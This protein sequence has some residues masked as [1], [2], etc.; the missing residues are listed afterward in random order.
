MQINIRNLEHIFLP[1]TPLAFRALNNINLSIGQGE[2]IGIIGQTGSGKTTFVEHLNGLLIP[3]SGEIEWSF[4]NSRIIKIKDKNSKKKTKVSEDFQ[5]NVILK[6]TWRKKFPQAKDIRKRLGIIFQFAEYQLFEET[7]EKDIIFGPKSFGISKKD[8]KLRA[9]KYL[10]LV[11]LDDSYLK[12]SPFDLSGGQKRR[13]ALAGILAMEPDI[14][15]ADEPTAGLDPVGVRE[16][17]NIFKKLNQMGKTIII[18]THDL[19]NV[20]EETKRVII[21]K[22]GTVVKDGDTYDILRDTKFLK[23]NEMEPP[24]LLAFVSKL[25][26]RGMRVPKI[27]SIEELANFLN[28]K[29]KETDNE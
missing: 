15:V 23:E 13:V 24:K 25:E 16:I 6:N 19:D 22:D 3:T 17:L 12:K 1:K 27:T 29:R 14:L 7:I 8:A 4:I 20:L 5:D 28:R 26:E 10:N 11:G 9:K 18:V 2:Y 21:F